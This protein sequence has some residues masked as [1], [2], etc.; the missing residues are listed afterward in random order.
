MT[1][2]NK[3]R[4]ALFEA[5]KNCLKVAL[6]S[7]GKLFLRAM[8]Y[9]SS[10]RMIP[11][12]IPGTKPAKNIA[13]IEVFVKLPKT[14]MVRHGGIRTPMPPAAVTRAAEKFGA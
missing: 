10:I 11:M 3:E 13:P 9:V 2:I 14:T 1:P 6:S 12:L 4:V 7:R 8:M 5:L